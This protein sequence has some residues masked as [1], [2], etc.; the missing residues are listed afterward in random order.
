[1]YGPVR[2]QRVEL[3][4]K[5]KALNARF[6]FDSRLEAVGELCSMGLISSATRTEIFIHSTKHQ[7]LQ[8][9]GFDV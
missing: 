1:V 2:F 5:V 9:P 3:N 6:K 8:V 7:A 4:S